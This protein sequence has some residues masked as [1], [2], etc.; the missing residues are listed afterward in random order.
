MANKKPEKLK[1]GD[2]FGEW[3]V[4]EPYSGSHKSFCRCSCGVERQVSNHALRNGMSKSCGHA[5]VEHG[6]ETKYKKTDAGLIGKTFGEL[7]VIERV[8]NKGRAKY[9]CKCTCGNETIVIGSNLTRG[10]QK[11]CSN[12]IHVTEEHKQNFVSAG[13]DKVE[14]K[15]VEDTNL[16][17]LTNKPTKRS[18]T[19]VRGVTYNKKRGMYIA[20]INFQKKYIYLGGYKTLEGAKKARERAEEK[21]FEPTLKKYADRLNDKKEGKDKNDD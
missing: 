21:Y 10:L 19:G 1:K 15:L 5:K 14:E 11:A 18:T 20:Y 7:T 12:P 2:R 9:R 17:N 8:N 16:F 13:R 3:T 6:N 4:I